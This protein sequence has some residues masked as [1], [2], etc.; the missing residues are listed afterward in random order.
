MCS[1]SITPR[2]R[3]KYAPQVYAKDRRRGGYIV[4]RIL[5]KAEFIPVAAKPAIAQ[6]ARALKFLRVSMTSSSLL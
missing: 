2:A 3:R 1:P 4:R 5:S 6:T